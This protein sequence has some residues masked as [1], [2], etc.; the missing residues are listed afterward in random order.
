M[1]ERELHI[2]AEEFGLDIQDI[3]KA[4]QEDKRIDELMNKNGLT[5]KNAIVSIAMEDSWLTE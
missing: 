3:R 2:L 5:R 1:T 4:A